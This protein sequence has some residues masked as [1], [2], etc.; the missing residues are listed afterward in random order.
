MLLEQVRVKGFLSH[1][2]RPQ[3][4]GDIAPVTVDFDA[5]PLWLVCGENGTGKSALV[6]DAVGFAFYKRHRGGGTSFGHLVHDDANEATVEVEFTLRGQRYQIQRTIRDRGDGRSSTGEQIYRQTAGEGEWTK[7]A[8]YDSV[9]QW[10]EEH[11]RMSYETFQSAVMLRQGEADVFLEA[12][13]TER[14]E[15]LME[16]I[17]LSFYRELERAA[18]RRKNEERD[19][20]RRLNEELE[21]LADATD[22]A[23]EQQEEQAEQAREALDQA[24]EKRDEKKTECQNARRAEKLENGIEE[25]R[26][27]R[28]TYQQLLDQKE[29]IKENVQ[30]ARNLERAVPNLKRLHDERGRLR[31]E[32]DRLEDHR[33]RLAELKEEI[34]L[35]EAGVE[36][37]CRVTEE[38]R[39]T[40][41]QVAS[42]HKTL[43]GALPPL[44]TFS[45]ALDAR[46]QRRDEQ[47]EAE[48]RLKTARAAESNA[49][50]RHKKAVEVQETAQENVSELRQALR[51]CKAARERLEECHQKRLDLEEE[52]VCPQCGQTLSKED[53]REHLRR[54]RRKLEGEIAEQREEH[55]RLES[56]LEEAESQQAEA[57]EGRKKADKELREARERE[58]RAES[59]LEHTRQQVQEAAS[60]LEESA[61][62]ARS[63]ASRLAQLEELPSEAASLKQA[64]A[65]G[66]QARA[67]L[68]REYEVFP[69]VEQRG[70]LRQ[71]VERLEQAT[72]ALH[73][74]H[75]CASKEKDEKARAQSEAEKQLEVCRNALDNVSQSVDEGAERVEQAEQA[76][77]D[78]KEALSEE[79]QEHPACEDASALEALWDE[80]QHLEGAGE[81]LEELQKAEREVHGI[82]SAIEELR[83][84]CENIPD[85]HRRPPKEVEEELGSAVGDAEEAEKARDEA[86]DELNE[87][88]RRRQRREKREDERDEAD[89]EKGYHQ[90]LT[91]AFGP[92]GL[93]GRIIRLA[94][95]RLRESA[96]K[97]LLK[98]SGGTLEI[99]LE[100]DG[101][102]L[103]IFVRDVTRPDAVRAFEYLSGGERFRVAVSLA[104]GIGQSITGGRPSDT[105]LIDEGFGALDESNRELMVEELRRLSE[106]VLE[107]GRV[108]VVSH[109]DDVQDQFPFRHVVTK[110]SGRATVEQSINN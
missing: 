89:R 32:Q 20:E 24:R 108:V 38:A 39:A 92:Q 8:G 87:L 103:E 56:E 28:Q 17:D 58:T 104:V 74:A 43:R 52:D 90:R 63:Q 66:E 26:E 95:Q 10:V 48:E 46:S 47:Q 4:G 99:D 18:K 49:E 94:Q 93:Q 97:T 15:R 73:D 110:E 13:P 105:L 101:E 25:K 12:K 57:K 65:A 61:V 2:G 35:T 36:E 83:D 109:Q 100:S 34:E 14:R 23:V 80:Q 88:R 54:E 29:D 1:Y 31:R 96:N 68:D 37:A 76:V 91:E 67:L 41:E 64:R 55:E 3:S 98:L 78:C 42:A 106:D 102:K 5:S 45:R 75:E 53:V 82:E 19:K 79:W 21:E 70:T 30:R 50:Q 62:E 9:T 71:H 59:G 7:V 22:E 84:Q 107:D 44:R 72:K 51:E 60:V 81:K 40:H 69:T 77:A 85:A 27:Q 16:L 86:R 11:L 6:F 33:N